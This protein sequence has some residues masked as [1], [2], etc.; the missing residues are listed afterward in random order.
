MNKFGVKI[1]VKRKSLIYF[2]LLKQYFE[3]KKC[4]ENVFLQNDFVMKFFLQ[5]KQKMC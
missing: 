4:D 1:F 3:E 2:F 5:R